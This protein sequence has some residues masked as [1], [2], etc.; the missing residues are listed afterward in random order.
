MLRPFRGP[1]CIPAA[2]LLFV[3]TAVAS[4]DPRRTPEVIVREMKVAEQALKAAVGDPHDMADAAKRVA[5][6]ARA[7]R[8]L[9]QLLTDERELA[10]GDGRP[11]PTFFEVQL[12]AIGGALGDPESSNALTALSANTATA[13]RGQGGQ[14]LARWL[15][16]PGDADAQSRVVDE[17]A[18]LDHAH[19]DSDDL[20]HF[21]GLMTGSAATPGV[22]DRLLALLGPMTSH[23][24][25]ILRQQMPATKP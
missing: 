24:A 9:Q 2:S 25:Q 3:A 15:Q 14:L 23:R 12:R 13:L 5:I 1:G 7:M 6:A 4:A 8:P 16:V 20:A 11:V 17:L 18:A 22:R 10:V 19:P 21:T